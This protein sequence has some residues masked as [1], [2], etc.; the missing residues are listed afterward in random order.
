MYTVTLLS[1]KGGVGKTTSAVHIAASAYEKGFRVLLIDLDFQG[2]VAKRL[3]HPNYEAKI[4]AGEWLKGDVSFSEVCLRT[5]PREDEERVGLIDM[6][7]GTSF[8]RDAEIYLTAKGDAGWLINRLIEMK[9]G[10]LE[11]DLIVID[12]HPS[13]DR[14]IVNAVAAADVVISPFSAEPDAYIGPKTAISRLEEISSTRRRQIPVYLLPTRYSLKN[15]SESKRL[16]EAVER[17]H[18]TW[19]N[20]LVLPHII[21]SDVLKNT[22][23]KGESIYES[24][25]GH[26]TAEQYNRIFEII[27]ETDHARV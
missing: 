13:D 23:A 1:F 2:A 6:V 21:D 18:G 16:V 27:E 8:L 12:T 15:G 17:V 5:R 14:L 11:Y 9:E 7:P 20:G 10:G 26:A 4:G 25:P 24:R 3:V 22:G 19:P